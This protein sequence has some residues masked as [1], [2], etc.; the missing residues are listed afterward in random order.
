FFMP[1]EGNMSI[2][3]LFL[4]LPYSLLKITRPRVPPQALD[5]GSKL[6][7]FLS[8]LFPVSFDFRHLFRAAFRRLS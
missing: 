4:S 6:L 8:S 3:Y 1:P 2:P 7:A 5:E